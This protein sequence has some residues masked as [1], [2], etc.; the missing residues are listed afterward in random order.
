MSKM[1]QEEVWSLDR[2]SGCG[3]CVA[4]CSKEVLYWGSHQHPILEER[5]KSIGL[6]RHRLQTCEVCEHF[7][8]I[9]CPRLTKWPPHDPLQVFSARSR[10]PYESGDPG[11]VIQ[12]MLI[13]ALSANLIDGVI[14]P[15]LDPWTL[16]PVPR[17]AT[18]VEE[19]VDSNLDACLWSPV[20]TALNEAI[21]ECGLTKL[22]IVGPPCVAE[23]V[24]QLLASQNTRLHPYQPAIRFVI[25][26][27][28]AGTYLPDLVVGLVEKATGLQAR[29]IQSL[30]VSQPSGE[31]TVTSFGGETHAIPLVEVESYTR[32]GCG[33]CND[34]LG[35]Q[36]DIGIG[37]VGAKSEHCTMI[38]RTRAGQILLENALKYELLQTDREV[39]Q[40]A[41]DK[42]RAEKDRRVIA[43]EFDEFYILM[44]DA[45]QDPRKRSVV[46]KQFSMLYG[47]PARAAKK[48]EKNDVACGGC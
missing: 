16:K 5:Q 34:F 14:L 43:Q 31:L 26:H 27:F 42:A 25:S 35:E 10:G 19:I 15:D 40:S 46:R 32:Q 28:C 39:D 21:F 12:S 45:L 11:S 41:I 48:Q 9:C 6:S 18:S 30:R 33:S 24:R 23:G 38:V 20:L 8:E 37:M 7:C 2:C 22:A 4:V 29:Q 36:G 17:I 3:L 1:L 13:A 47:A 44:L